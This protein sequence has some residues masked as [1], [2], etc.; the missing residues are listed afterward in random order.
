MSC[1]KIGLITQG[2]RPTG[3]DLNAISFGPHMGTR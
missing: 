1:N 3:G 2:E